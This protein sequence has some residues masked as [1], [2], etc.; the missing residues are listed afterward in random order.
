VEALM[1]MA[2]L[3][4]IAVGAFLALVV[5]WIFGAN[6]LRDRDVAS[7]DLRKLRLDLHKDGWNPDRIGKGPV[8]EPT[9]SDFANVFD[10]VETNIGKERM[11]RVF[12]K[13]PAKDLLEGFANDPRFQFTK[14]ADGNLMVGLN[15]DY[16]A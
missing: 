8:V 16:E 1:Q 2:Y 15:E 10:G 3:T 11:E 6:V 5:A 7:E 4:G 9:E 13:D 14:D 12:G